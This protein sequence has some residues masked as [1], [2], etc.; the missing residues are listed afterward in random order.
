MLVKREYTNRFKNDECR[1]KCD[2]CNAD[3]TIKNR[4]QL[5]LTKPNTNTRQ[6]YADLCPRCMKA[7]HRG[8]KRGVK[9]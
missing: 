2:R 9:V 5:A 7:F 6:K 4:Y 3:I 8:I 1:Y